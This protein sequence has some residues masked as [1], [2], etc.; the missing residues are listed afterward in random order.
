MGIELVV[1][2]EL[3]PYFPAGLT[4]DVVPAAGHFMHLDQPEHVRRHVLEFLT[5]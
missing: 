5:A 2:H 3:T 1:E 4:L